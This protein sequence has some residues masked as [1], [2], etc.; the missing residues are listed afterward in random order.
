MM[1]NVIAARLVSFIGPMS[2]VI[3]AVGIFAT[4]YF[5]AIM[6]AGGEI[7]LGIL[8][9]FYMWINNLFRPVQ[10]LTQF[11]PQYQSAMTGLDRILQIIDAEIDV[12][13]TMKKKLDVDFRKYKILG[14]CNPPNAYKALQSEVDIGLMLPCNVVVYELEE[15][16]TVVAAI[17]PVASMMAVENESLGVTAG[18]VAKIGK[19]QYERLGLEF[20]W[21]ISSTTS[22]SSC[23]RP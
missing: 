17:D 7:E 12:K 9:A 8:T 23:T 16:K 6:V 22:S 19:Q 5:G 15:G 14:A 21:F 3:Q 11:Y 18:E 1:A 20:K 2:Q 10:Q 13:E 4:F